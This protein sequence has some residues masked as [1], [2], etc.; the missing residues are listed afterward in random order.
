MRSGPA[1]GWGVRVEGWGYYLE[2]ALMEAGLLDDYPRTRELYLIF[3]MKRAVR[4]HADIMM[5]LNELTVPEAVTYM[6]DRV[7]Y[8]DDDVS[9]VDAEIY[10]RR[11][12]GYGLSYL[13]GGLQIDAM[14]ADRSRQLGDDFV[15]RDFHDEFMA[16]GR[17][18]VS[19]LRWEMTGLDDEARTLWEWSPVR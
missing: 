13:I 9:R 18:P 7:P 16:L 1:P 3:G 2:G 14:L 4:V 17:L 10:L 6:V 15:L 11:P 8:L 12:P 5:Q 19:L